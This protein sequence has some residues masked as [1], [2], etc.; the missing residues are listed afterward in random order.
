MEPFITS[1]LKFSSSFLF[2]VSQ[3]A[4]VELSPMLV[5]LAV[6][7]IVARINGLLKKNTEL[8]E[9]QITRDQEALINEVAQS[10]VRSINEQQRAAKNAHDRIIAEHGMEDL[11]KPGPEFSDPEGPMSLQDKLNGVPQPLAPLE[12]K[13]LALE[14]LRTAFPDQPLDKLETIV[15]AAVAQAR[16]FKEKYMGLKQQ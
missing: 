16:I 12:R 6:S 1:I 15:L 7:L 11:M 14:R 3:R 13:E 5:T 9:I 10:I 4:L 8:K 2:D